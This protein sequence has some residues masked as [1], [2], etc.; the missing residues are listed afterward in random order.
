M[1]WSGLVQLCRAG[2]AQQGS[3]RVRLVRELVGAGWLGAIQLKNRKINKDK[4]ATLAKVICDQQ[5]W[6]STN[7]NCSV[8]RGVKVARDASQVRVNSMMLAELMFG[9][10]SLN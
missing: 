10:G 5:R 1:L 8:A 3:G 4:D 6:R 7:S 2:S 9:F